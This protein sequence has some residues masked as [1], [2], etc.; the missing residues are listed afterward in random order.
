M[1]PVILVAY[2]HGTVWGLGTGFAFSLVQMLLGMDNIAWATSWIAGVAIIALDYLLAFTSLGFAGLLR[3]GRL[4][5][6]ASLTLGTLLCCAIRYLCHVVSGCTVWAGVSIPSTDGLWYSLG[7]N[8][9]YMVPETI[10]TVAGAFYLS[11]VL[12][13]SSAGLTRIRRSVGRTRSQRVWSSAGLFVAMVAVAFDAVYLFAHLQNEHGFDITLLQSANW[14]L[15]VL[16]AVVGAAALAISA[17]FGRR[18]GRA[19]V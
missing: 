17:F 5:Q 14:F 6:S 15:I 11:Q 13:F 8:A 7:Y 4:S 10:V 18:S 1:L 9:A 3:S 12:D 16:V 2:R 19:Q